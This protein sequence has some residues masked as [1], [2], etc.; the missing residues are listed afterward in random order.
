M[1]ERVGSDLN[2]ALQPSG[3][4]NLGAVEIVDLPEGRLEEAFDLSV[5]RVPQMTRVD[6]GWQYGAPETWR[7]LVGLVATDDRDRLLGWGWTARA[8][9]HDPDAAGIDVIVAAE[10]EGTGIGTA[11]FAALRDRL[12]PGTRVLRTSA[13]DDDPRSL[14]V[15]R[16]WGFQVRTHSINARLPL[17][18]LPEPAPPPDVTLESSGTLTFDDE[19]AVD[20]M[21]VRSQT[22]PEARAGGRFDGTAVLRSMVAPQET[23]VGVLARV[24]GAPAA[25]VYGGI[26]DGLLYVVYTGVDPAHRGRGLARLAKQRAHLDARA[27]GATAAYTNNEE[28]NAG[29]RRVNA[30]LGYVVESGTYR[31]TL[32][33]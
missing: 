10:H 16:H 29:I 32:R 30:E 18:D 20:A 28:R 24:D 12:P 25:I 31:M 13:Y 9:F 2:T 1:F 33:L 19:P 23:V 6:A 14:A 4:G 8:T 7:H 15:A 27:A 21:L 26:L 11:L 17:T 5:A 3:S 22:N